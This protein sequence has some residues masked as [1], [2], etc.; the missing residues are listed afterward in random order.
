VINIAPLEFEADMT[1]A[2]EDTRVSRRVISAVIEVVGE[3]IEIIL[4]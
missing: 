3:V 4:S 2:F 1:G